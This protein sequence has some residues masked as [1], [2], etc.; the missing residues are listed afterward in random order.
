MNKFGLS[1]GVSF[2]IRKTSIGFDISG[3]RGYQ[4]V[5]IQEWVQFAKD[6][7][8]LQVKDIKSVQ[9]HPVGP[10]SFI[11]FFEVER[12]RDVYDE[13]KEGILWP[14]KG[15]IFPFLCTEAYTEVKLK[16]LEPGTD[17]VTVSSIM[18]DYGEVLSCREYRVKLPGQVGDGFPTGDYLLRMKIKSKIPRFLPNAW[19]GNVWLVTYEGQEDECWRCWQPGHEKRE[20]KAKPYAPVFIDE[21]VE[22]RNEYL[23]EN[24]VAGSAPGAEGVPP[25]LVASKGSG[26]VVGGEAEGE[27]RT[28]SALGAERVPPGQV[29]SPGRGGV[30]GGEAE[31]DFVPGNTQD[32]NEAMDDFEN[33]SLNGDV[34]LEDPF[35]PGDTQML[36]N[37]LDKAESGPSRK[38]DRSWSEHGGS[39]KRMTMVTRNLG[40]EQDM[41]KG[42][43]DCPLPKIL[44]KDRL[45][46][47]L[48][49]R[50]TKKD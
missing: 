18:S 49:S 38:H 24:S 19:D 43:E 6:I 14:N 16:G 15:E 47:Q 33:Q 41:I 30:V 48:A 44:P 26:G 45:K 37:A 28:G 17:L 36:C 7:L 46:M 12:M 50:R 9:V 42:H 31:G 39:P 4:R 8:K 23:K 21:Q 11:E 20:C 35:P 5:R 27:G 32:L 29:A 1:P 3:V 34:D 40:D 25:S 13:I 22:R 10:Y 2:F